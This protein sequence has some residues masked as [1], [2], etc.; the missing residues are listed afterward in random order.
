[1]ES[2]D[3]KCTLVLDEILDPGYSP[4]IEEVWTYAVE[5]LQMAPDVNMLDK[6]LLYI[7][8]DALTQPLPKGWKICQQR[9]K[10]RPGTVQTYYF[11]FKTGM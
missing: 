1:M 5:K 11:N 6:S 7:A 3:T 8:R 2:T 4:T 9:S 10:A